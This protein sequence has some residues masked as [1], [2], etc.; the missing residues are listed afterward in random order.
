MAVMV[1][2]RLA[3][4]QWTCWFCSRAIK[5]GRFIA[6]TEKTKVEVGCVSVQAVLVLTLAQAMPWGSQWFY[7]IEIAHLRTP[8]SEGYILPTSIRIRNIADQSCG[9]G[10]DKTTDFFSGIRHV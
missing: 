9:F 6:T 2:Y 5:P 4:K 10:G 7:P 1:M 3:R 8:S